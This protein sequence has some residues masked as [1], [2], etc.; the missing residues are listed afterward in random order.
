[1]YCHEKPVTVITVPAVS[2]T[3]VVNVSPASPGRPGHPGGRVTSPL[4]KIECT[5]QRPVVGN[6]ITCDVTA[7]QGSGIGRIDA[8]IDGRLFRTCRAAT[9]TFTTPPID[10]AP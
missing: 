8:W 10:E 5:P 1:M 7:E 4:L 9:C 2:I 3:R 6:E